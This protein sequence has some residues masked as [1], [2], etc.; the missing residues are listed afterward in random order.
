MKK[1]YLLPSVLFVFTILGNLNAQSFERG[2]LHFDLGIGFGVYGTSQKSTIE[3]TFL[4]VTTSKTNDTT[5]GTASMVIP[6][7]FE[8]GLTDKIGLGADLTINNYIISDSDKV[9]LNS[10]KAFDFGPRF[11]YHLI[12][13]ERNELFIGVG[14]GFS[15]IKWTYVIN[16]PLT[17]VIETATGSGIY[18]SLSINDRIFISDHVGLLF[19]VSYKGYKY[20]SIKANYTSSFQSIIN[21]SGGN[22]TQKWDWNLNGVNVGAGL[23]FKF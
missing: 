11:N 21:S 8:Y 17:D 15:S 7:N 14:L 5:D 12:N 18:Y 6:L 16:D 22:I 9:N 23:A 2:S 1:N 3:T 20:S 10:V 19:N 4:G 13:S